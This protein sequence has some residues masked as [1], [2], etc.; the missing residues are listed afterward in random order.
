MLFQK[1]GKYIKISVLEGVR[2]WRDRDWRK[3]FGDEARVGNTPN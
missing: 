2:G 1:Q 3:K